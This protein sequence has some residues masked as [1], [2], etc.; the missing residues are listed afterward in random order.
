MEQRVY[1]RIS[2]CTL[3]KFR[4]WTEGWLARDGRELGK[5]GGALD[6][7]CLAMSLHLVRERFANACQRRRQCSAVIHNCAGPRT[8]TGYQGVWP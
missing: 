3:F 1:S 5:T 8:A 7:A 6:A 4:A 2:L